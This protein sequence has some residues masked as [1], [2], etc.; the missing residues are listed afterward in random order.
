MHPL[1]F[2]IKTTSLLLFLL[3]NTFLIYA[4]EIQ[5][6]SNIWYF[7]NRA[8]LDFNTTPPTALVNGQL[9]TQEGVATVSNDLGELLFYT[10][11]ITVWDRTHQAMP[12]ANGTLNG[13]FSS[14]QSVVCNFTEWI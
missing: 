8:G 4:Q 6:S 2:L 5:N 13:H 3:L 12:N 9:N 11:G 10:D 1:V 14:T 7:G